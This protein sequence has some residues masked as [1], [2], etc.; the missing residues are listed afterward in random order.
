VD[1]R[2][3]KDRPGKPKE[4]KEKTGKR[5]DKEG[6]E[7]D[8]RKEGKETTG[9][10]K[11]ESEGGKRQEENFLNTSS[12][13]HGRPWENEGSWGGVQQQQQQGQLQGAEESLR[14]TAVV[15]PQGQQEWQPA[16]GQ[17]QEWEPAQEREE[18]EEWSER[19][20]ERWRRRVEEIEE[21]MD[22]VNC[23]SGEECVLGMLEMRRRRMNMFL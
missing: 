5:K 12:G 11:Q 14:H 20:C 7:K 16:Q 8:K 6:R 4:G 10:R 15:H 1:K 9:K 17:Q 13:M 19:R 23:R 22:K 2:S 18:R 21:K 3:G